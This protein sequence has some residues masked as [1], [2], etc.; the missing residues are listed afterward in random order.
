[1]AA[2]EDAAYIY[3]NPPAAGNILL[4]LVNNEDSLDIVAVITKGGDKTP[5]LAIYV[6]SSEV[7]SIQKMEKGRYDVYFTTGIDWNE[8]KNKFNDGNYYKFKTPLILG[9]KNEY[10]L[11]M[12]ADQGKMGTR[13]KFIDESVFPIISGAAYLPDFGDSESLSNPVEE[14]ESTPSKKNLNISSALSSLI[15]K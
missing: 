10:Q 1:M 14:T 5:L 12:Y 15:D 8:D 4:K 3:G 9:E 2:G 7:G 11:P 6:P 13:I